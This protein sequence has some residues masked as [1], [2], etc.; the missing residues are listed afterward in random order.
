ML[1]CAEAIALLADY[2]EAELGSVRIGSLEDHLRECDECVTYLNTY[3]KTRELAAAAA[4]VEM[5]EAMKTRLRE[6]LVA[7]LGKPH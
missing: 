3:R 4:R 7:S 5:P 1:T 2:L 6:F